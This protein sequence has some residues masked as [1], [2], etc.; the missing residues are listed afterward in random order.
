[1]NP[2]LTVTDVAARLMISKSSVYRLLDG[3]DGLPHYTLGTIIRIDAAELDAWLKEHRQCPSGK[4][5]EAATTP[6]SSVGESA[7]IESAR[8]RRRGGTRNASKPSSSASSVRP[9]RPSP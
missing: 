2:L 1:M 3:A 6:P 4:T 9:L 8:R 7:Y 5:P